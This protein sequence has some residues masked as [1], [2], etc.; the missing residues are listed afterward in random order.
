MEYDILYTVAWSL[1]YTD[2]FTHN[3]SPFTFECYTHN[4]NIYYVHDHN[5]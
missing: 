5:F 3:F 1:F 4:R 2:E